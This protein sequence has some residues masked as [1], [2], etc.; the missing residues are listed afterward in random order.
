MAT[1]LLPTMTTV[2]VMSQDIGPEVI[3]YQVQNALKMFGW[4]HAT[5]S[6]LIRFTKSEYSGFY[7]WSEALTLELSRTFQE[8]V[9]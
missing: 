3:P 8:M 6:G 5:S 2:T 9:R 1:T 4:T 7:T